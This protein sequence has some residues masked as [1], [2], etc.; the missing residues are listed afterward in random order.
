MGLT[1]YTFDV[2]LIFYWL[3]FYVYFRI[4][5]SYACSAVSVSSGTLFLNPTVT[6]GTRRKTKDQLY[7][8]WMCDCGQFISD[9]L[10]WVC[11]FNF[12][13]CESL[14]FACL[15]VFNDFDLIYDIFIYIVRMLLTQFYLQ[16]N[17][18]INGRSLVFSG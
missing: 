8:K 4:T 10:T 11:F 16:I 3:I 13:L 9:L 17:V 7:E 6:I 2:Q 12:G 14:F 15:A 5:V 1:V 18:S